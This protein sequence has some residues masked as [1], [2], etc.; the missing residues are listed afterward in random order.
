MVA[1]AKPPARVTSSAGRAGRGSSEPLLLLEKNRSENRRP[2]FP[3][4]LELELELSLE[5]LAF[6]L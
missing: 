6:E 1:Q 5:M 3:G 2:G 4:Y